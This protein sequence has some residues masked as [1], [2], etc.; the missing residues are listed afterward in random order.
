MAGNCEAGG[1]VNS[2]VIV[3]F[4]KPPYSAIHN[5]AGLT[6]YGHSTDLPGIIPPETHSVWWQAEQHHL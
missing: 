4:T 2:A 1:F 6:V 3:H 5:A